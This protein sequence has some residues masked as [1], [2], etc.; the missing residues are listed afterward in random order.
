VKVE[1]ATEAAAGTA[2]AAPADVQAA[3]QRLD[4]WVR[5]IVGWHFSPDTGCPFWL[6]RAA[7]LGW[8]PKREVRS[9]ACL[10]RFGPFDPDTLRRRSLERW[11][12]RGLAGKPFAVFETG[13][14]QAPL[15]RLS[16]E[17][18]MTDFE[19]LSRAL[20]E[21]GFPRGADWISLGPMGPRR[22]R[23]ALE[24][25]VQTRGGIL[26]SLDM[27]ARWVARCL[28]RGA[29][30]RAEAY[31]AHVVDQALTILRA[32][33]G[34]R[35]LSATPKLLEAL[36]DKVSL[37]RQGLTGVLLSGEAVSAEFHRR[38]RE[39][40]CAGGVE[41]FPAY[42]NTLS[43]VAVSKP[44]LAEDGYQVTYYSPQPRAVIEVVDPREPSRPIA[45]GQVGRLK[46]TTLTREL[47]LPGFLDRDE[48]RRAAPIA[49]CPW[50]GICDVR[51]S[52]SAGAG[53]S[54]AAS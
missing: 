20:P 25:L 33:P 7:Q 30:D 19:A 38:A 39:E 12:P 13:P 2:P 23:L 8:D 35:C 26:F 31:K 49:A 18:H 11:I 24:H 40:L 47:F 22:S 44:F 1:R 21:S 14:V 51:P 37:A 52:A 45:Y 27:D 3:Q 29:A 4:A 28:G 36:C 9:F 54:A 43:A 48:A 17:D 46:L 41:L 50:D 6:E 32:H 42:T 53:L 16:F 15:C 10:A 5:D 34:I